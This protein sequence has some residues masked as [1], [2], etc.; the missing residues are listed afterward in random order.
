MGKSPV[1]CEQVRKSP[2]AHVESVHLDSNANFPLD[3]FGFRL[4]RQ[5]AVSTSDAEFND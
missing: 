2:D 3:G 4:E 5:Q 1:V